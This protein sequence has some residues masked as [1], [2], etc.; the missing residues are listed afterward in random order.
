[1]KLKNARRLIRKIIK[2]EY[3]SVDR[4]ELD[5]MVDKEYGLYKRLQSDKKEE[6][7][8]MLLQNFDILSK[9]TYSSSVTS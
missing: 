7:E 2:M 5:Q 1:M 6:Y 9:Q 8:R 4:L 3:D